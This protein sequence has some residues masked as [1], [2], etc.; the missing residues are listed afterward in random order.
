MLLANLIEE[1][2][3]TLPGLPCQKY[4]CGPSLLI[5]YFNSFDILVCNETAANLATFARFLCK[6]AFFVS[7]CL[8][9]SPELCTEKTV[10][11]Q[12]HYLPGLPCYPNCLFIQ[13]ILLLLLDHRTQSS[14][15]SHSCIIRAD[16]FGLLV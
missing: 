7:H 4:L 14:A 15:L 8:Y 11:N 9:L 3:V 12:N 6:S 10:Q 1:D 5:S 16:I 2:S 13:V